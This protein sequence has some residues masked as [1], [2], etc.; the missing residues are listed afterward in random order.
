M[1]W[2]IGELWTHPYTVAVS[3]CQ[4]Q[5][6]TWSAQLWLS[7]GWRQ[8]LMRPSA[9]SFAPHPSKREAR[10][11]QCSE[12]EEL[13]DEAT[14]MSLFYN[15]TLG[16]CQ[17]GTALKHNSNLPSVQKEFILIGQKL[18]ED[19]SRRV[20]DGVFKPNVWVQR[21]ILCDVQYALKQFLQV[22]HLGIRTSMRKVYFIFRICKNIL[23]SPV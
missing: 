1:D 19:F 2:S 22:W 3:F 10:S 16:Y 9:L 11:A 17:A 14:R 7:G 21:W 20:K 5:S 8:S 13:E 4:V 23:H 15:P 6:S 12:E 18:A